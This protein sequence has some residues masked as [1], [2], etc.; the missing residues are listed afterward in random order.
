MARWSHLYPDA[1]GDDGAPTPLLDDLDDLC[2]L[3]P[4][5]LDDDDDDDED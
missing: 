1:G 5:N 4:I 2:D 3:D